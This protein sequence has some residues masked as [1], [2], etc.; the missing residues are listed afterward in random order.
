MIG[1]VYLVGAGPSAQGLLTLRGF[2]VLQKAQVVIYDALVGM[3][4]LNLLPS[5]ARRIYVGKRAGHHTI[6]QEEM[7]ELLLQ[8]A[9]AGNCVV[10]LK[11]GDPF[12][13]GRGGEELELL[14]QHGIPFEIVP[15]VTSA[16]AVPAYAGIPVTHR[17][18]CSSVHIITGHTKKEPQAATD[19]KALVHLGGTLIFLMGVS[20]METICDGLLG[21]G[22]SPDMPAAVLEQGTTA[23]QRRI[24]GSVSTIVAAAR[25]AAVKAPAI[26][27]VG[28]VCALAERFSW[29]ESR[30]LNTRRFIVTRPKEQASKMAASLRDLGAEVLE[31]PSIS[32]VPISPNPELYYALEEIEAYRWLVL[33]SPAGAAIFLQQLREMAFDLRRLHGIRLAAIG[34]ATAAALKDAGLFADLVPEEFYASALGNALAKQIG[35]MLIVR[36]REGA[37]ELTKA[38][39]ESGIFYRDIPLYDTCYE[40]DDLSTLAQDLIA[41]GEIDGAVFTS[42]STVHGF[43][44]RIGT[45]LLPQVRAFCIGRSTAQA[46]TAY[47]MQVQI[48][49]EPSIAALTQLMVTDANQN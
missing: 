14:T 28:E 36:A 2:E 3:E 25:T 21:A 9:Q 18:Y 26:L 11:G 16:L 43:A 19:Y 29:T 20:S 33:T 41:Q 49:S 31:L 24:A 38:L 39:E 22:I 1:K 12:L 47:G 48:A 44:R 6:P 27:I 32:I 17:A 37:P 15:G 23:R 5:G 40:Q 10:R 4:L 7:N 45:A 30:P 42:A 13:F 46:A 35:P 8:E 34:S